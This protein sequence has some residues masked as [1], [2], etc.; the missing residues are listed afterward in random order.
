MFNN[1]EIKKRIS[2]AGCICIYQIFQQK[3]W[4]PHHLAWLSSF[5]RALEI[6]EREVAADD[7]AIQ[8][9][10]TLRMFDNNRSTQQA[11]NFIFLL[12]L[13]EFKNVSTNNYLR[14]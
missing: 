13:R 3:N 11:R 2:Y 8:T 12:K 9:I 5:K 7:H 1:F 14:N 6:E 4:E 10:A